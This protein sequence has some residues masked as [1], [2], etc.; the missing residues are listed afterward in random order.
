MSNNNSIQHQN[1]TVNSE[2]QQIPK[3]KNAFLIWRVEVL[4]LIDN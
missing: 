3:G 1:N 2:F 4:I